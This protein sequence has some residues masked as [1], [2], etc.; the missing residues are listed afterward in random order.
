MSVSL[1]IPRTIMRL[2][3]VATLMGLL[4]LPAAGVDAQP[5]TIRVGYFPNITHVQALVARSFE[6]QGRGWF[7]ERLGTEVKIVWY[8]Y[9]AGPSAMESACTRLL[10]IRPIP[11][12]SRI[13]LNPS[14]AAA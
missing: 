4:V 8:A 11:P 13:N 14:F 6:R 10:R 5:L 3:K 9:N 1:A 12:V 7:Q 2:A